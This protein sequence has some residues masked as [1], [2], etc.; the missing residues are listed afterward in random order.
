MG[1]FANDVVHRLKTKLAQ[2][3]PSYSW[4]TEH[5]IAKTPVDVAGIDDNQYILIELE[6]RR[7]DPA[8]NVAKIFRHLSKGEMGPDRILII[9]VFTEYY[10][11]VSGGVSSKRKNAEFVGEIAADSLSNLIY[12]PLDYEI[13]PPKSGENR[14]SDWEA[15]TDSIATKISSELNCP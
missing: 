15:T 4:E 13:N 8:D 10:D 7:A 14:P 11:L 5:R 1:E 9:Q 6:W 3:C 2:K 12:L